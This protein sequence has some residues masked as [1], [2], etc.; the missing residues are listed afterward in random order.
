MYTEV[1]IICPIHGEFLIKPTKHIHGKYGC[2]K[3]GNKRKGKKKSIL[4][5]FIEKARKVHR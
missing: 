4:N 5:I 3:C 1:C 2:S